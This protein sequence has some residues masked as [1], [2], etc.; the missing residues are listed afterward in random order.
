MD[1]TAN[2]FHQKEKQ[3]NYSIC[4]WVGETISVPPIVQLVL[5]MDSCTLLNVAYNLLYLLRNVKC[6]GDCGKIR[7][8]IACLPVLWQWYM[9]QDNSSET[10]HLLSNL[11]WQITMFSRKKMTATCTSTKKLGIFFFFFFG[12][13]G[14]EWYQSVT[15]FC[16]QLCIYQSYILNI[17]AITNMQIF[18]A[19]YMYFKC[20]HKYSNI[21]ELYEC[22][23]MLHF[24]M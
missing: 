7:F 22:M 8:Q 1:R 13:G 3:V 23:I 12:G 11:P 18:L 10:L 16:K 19:T 17:D 24:C 6:L 15:L 5:K 20:I 2:Y 9:P 4:I 14:G 21:I